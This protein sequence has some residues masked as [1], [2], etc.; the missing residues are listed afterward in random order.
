MHRVVLSEVRRGEEPR[1]L[2]EREDEQGH[3]GEVD[4]VRRLTQTDR[5]EEQGHQATLRLGLASNARDRR[6]TGE[7]VTDRGADGTT[8]EGEPTA[9][10]RTGGLDG[11]F[12]RRC[13]CHDSPWLF[14]RATCP[15][16]SVGLS[17]EL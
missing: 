5:E 2:A 3:E 17:V 13:V 6:A 4:E 15:V 16:T 14:G 12:H 7:P 10:Q 1:L 9:D 11:A 8:G